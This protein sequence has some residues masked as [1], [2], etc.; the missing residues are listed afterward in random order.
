MRIRATSVVLNEDNIL[1]IHRFNHGEEYYV[2]PGGGVE[3]GENIETAVTRE[4]Q[5][6]T[7]LQAKHW[8]QIGT[9]QSF[10]GISDEISHTFLA[11]SLSS[12]AL[13]AQKEKGI[14]EVK[15]M[16]IKKVM[17]LIKAGKITDGQTIAAIT[18]AALY[19]KII[20][21]TKEAHSKSRPYKAKEKKMKN[22]FPTLLKN[23][24]KNNKK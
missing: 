15:K 2:L 4:L 23:S 9:F 19:L 6:E 22:K 18:Q 11:T 7:G 8:K 14:V 13:H 1:M 17:Q 10:N 20:C 16:P 12:T 21:K 5:E 3:E 24:K